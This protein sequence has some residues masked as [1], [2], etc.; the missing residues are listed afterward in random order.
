MLVNASG[1]KL[2]IITRTTAN[3][4]NR[5][6]MVQDM[7]KRVGVD[8]QI[9]VVPVARISD[10]EYFTKFPGVEISARGSQDAILTRVECEERPSPQNA[11]A[12]NNRGQW[13]N[14]DYERL[15]ALYRTS[16]Q[17]AR[18]GEAIRQISD[19]LVEEL[20]L[21]LLNYQVANPFARKG[22]TAYLDDFPGGAEAGRIY[23]T[24]SRNAHEW[25]L[26]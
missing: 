4:V 16:L 20:P 7:W 14:Q 19:L 1:E 12:G 15:V 22:V 13:C 10:R 8:S 17:E 24:Y 11:Y 5:A 2:T 3:S 25:D 26:L 23:G 9:A 18:R 21:M 6:S